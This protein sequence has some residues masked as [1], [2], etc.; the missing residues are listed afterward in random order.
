M[1]QGIRT[2]WV[3]SNHGSKALL[4]RGV[5]DLEVEGAHARLVSEHDGLGDKRSCRGKNPRFDCPVLWSD[6]T[7][8]MVTAGPPKILG[9]LGG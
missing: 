1:R 8:A 7:T 4:A 6:A 2:N 3:G 9:G 5:P